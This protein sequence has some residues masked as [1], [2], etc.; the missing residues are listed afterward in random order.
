MQFANSFSVKDEMLALNAETFSNGT[1]FNIGASNVV[2]FQGWVNNGGFGG[3]LPTYCTGS[4]TSANLT[5]TN[6]L[7]TYGSVT[8]TASAVATD[9]DTATTAAVDVIPRQELCSALATTS[10]CILAIGRGTSGFDNGFLSFNGPGGT[11]NSLSLLL[12][13]MSAP[14][15][16]VFGNGNV[17]IPAGA[18]NVGGSTFT[19]STSVASFTGNWGFGTGVTINNTSAGGH[20]WSMSSEGA[21]E[22]PGIFFFVDN[23]NTAYPLTMFSS[24]S[25]AT[26]LLTNKSGTYAFSSTDT[27]FN[28]GSNQQAGF[29]SPASGVLSADTSTAGD[30][31]AEVK[32]A[33]IL[34]GVL[35]SAA[36]TALPACAA[37]NKGLKAVVSDATSPTYLGT[38]TSGGAVVS[39]VIC[40]GSGWVTY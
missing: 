1:I 34:P 33:S 21:S 32:M 17:A 11:A 5:V 16:S 35:Y 8:G 37:G 36:G 6:P 38:Y 30:G 10:N 24:S 25:T 13:G 3:V 23:T 12:S 9:T 27:P 7:A 4:C 28:N 39:P 20:S 18:L 29:S 2:N 31:L 26:K 22:T 15:L 19:P 40:N 14:G